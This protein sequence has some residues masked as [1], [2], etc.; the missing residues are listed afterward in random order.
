MQSRSCEQAEAGIK[1]GAGQGEGEPEDADLE[2]EGPARVWVGELREQGE[3]DQ[4]T[5]GFRPLTPTPVQRVFQG[6]LDPVSV[7]VLGVAG[8][9][10]VI[11]PCH[12]R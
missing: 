12:I 3:E 8:W 2:S 11:A 7:S 9:R 6:D 10:E 5:L 1:D 4:Q